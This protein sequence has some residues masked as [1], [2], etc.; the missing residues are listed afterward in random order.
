MFMLFAVTLVACNEETEENDEVERIIPVETAEAKIENLTIKKS[1]YGRVEPKDLTPVLLP[2]A[3]ELTELNVENGDLVEE[4]D[5]IAKIT[6]QAGV[7]NIYAP[8]DGEIVQLSAKEDSLVSNE[9][10]LALILDLEELTLSF[11]VTNNIRVLFDDEESLQAT[12]DE[13]TY[14]IEVESIGKMPDDTGLYPIE[15]TIKNKDKK[16]LPGM[17]GIVSL[18]EKRVKD[19]IILPTEAIIEESEGSFVYKVENDH[20]TKIDIEIIESQTDKTAIEGEISEGD[21]IVI[22]GQ[23]TLSDGSEV[24]VMKEGNES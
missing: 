14:D 23:L 7:Q 6:T 12:I 17:I 4:D 10:P 18:P 9:D 8:A 5:L 1:V 11:G 2:M 24:E 21:E 15:A 22:N 13:E 20:V 19:A 3:G 16:A